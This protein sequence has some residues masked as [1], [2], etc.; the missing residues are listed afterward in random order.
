MDA[1]NGH[2][3]VLS[4]VPVAILPLNLHFIIHSEEVTPALAL[5]HCLN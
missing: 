4:Y 3:L 5:H 1:C 2:L